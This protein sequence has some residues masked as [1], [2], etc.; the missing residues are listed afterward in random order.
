MPLT[1]TFAPTAVPPAVHVTGALAC[2]PNTLKEIVPVGL[3]P[4]ASVEPI[5]P[6]AIVVFVASVAGAAT[7]AVVLYFTTVEV[8]PVPQVLA[9]ALLLLSPG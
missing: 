8:M 5:E 3:A 2:G 1:V 7:V 6:A 4:P 9:D